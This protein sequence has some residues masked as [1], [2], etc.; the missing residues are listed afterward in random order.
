MLLVQ[1][2]WLAPGAGALQLC[3]ATSVQLRVHLSDVINI[4]GCGCGW[5]HRH[6]AIV[7]LGKGGR[8]AATHLTWGSSQQPPGVGSCSIGGVRA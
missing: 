7:G 6:G 4:H 5:D 3:T 1:G 2:G 8:S